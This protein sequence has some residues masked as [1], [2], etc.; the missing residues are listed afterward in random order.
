MYSKQYICNQCGK[1]STRLINSKC[2]ETK[3]D[4]TVQYTYPGGV[5]KNK[6]SVFEELEEMGVHVREEDRY[7][8]WFASYD[9]EAYQQ[10]FLGIRYMFQSRLVWGVIWEGL[11][12]FM[13]PVKTLMS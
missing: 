8:K 9:F 3:C 5:Y 10:D 12:L 13:F 1:L 11:K 7:E 6:L 4:G 2:H